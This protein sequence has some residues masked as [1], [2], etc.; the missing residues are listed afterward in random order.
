MKK[1]V[2]ILPVLLVLAIFFAG[3][4]TQ[5]APATTPAPAATPDPFFAASWRMAAP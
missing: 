4:T 3:C 1:T 5:P 2:M